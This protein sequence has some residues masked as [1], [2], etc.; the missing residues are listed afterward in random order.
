MLYLC[1]FQILHCVHL[2]PYTLYM[3]AP[4]P[5]LQGQHTVEPP[6]PHHFP[7]LPDGNSTMC[8]AADWSICLFL[9][10]ASQATRL[11][12]YLFYCRRL[13]QC[14]PFYHMYGIFYFGIN[15]L[16]ASVCLSSNTLTD[17]TL[18]RP[19]PTPL[20]W[21]SWHTTLHCIN[22][23]SFKQQVLQDSVGF[24]TRESNLKCSTILLGLGSKWFFNKAT[25]CTKVFSQAALLGH[26][27]T[28]EKTSFLKATCTGKSHREPIAPPHSLKLELQQK[29]E[30]KPRY[31]IN[32]NWH[33]I[34][35]LWFTVAI[36]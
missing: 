3:V 7:P 21:E 10:V 29:H 2:S 9:K 18:P 36:N 23:F 27:S 30:T 8:Y 1:Q 35:N 13:L 31:Y 16:S 34:F 17:L 12:L 11:V 22:I 6:V 33:S 28:K 19:G 20:F 4:C 26:Q 5:P 32:K 15:S 25:N 24:L 14:V